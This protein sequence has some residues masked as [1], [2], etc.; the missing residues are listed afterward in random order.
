M[1]NI[2]QEDT[3]KY[4]QTFNERDQKFLEFEKPIQEVSEKISALKLADI[5]NPAIKS[6]IESL[7]KE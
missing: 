6:Q 4:E 3:N 2:K 5:W 7:E 1:N